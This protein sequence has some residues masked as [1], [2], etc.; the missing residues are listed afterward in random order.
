MKLSS[1]ELE[2][3]MPIC[4]PNSNNKNCIVYKKYYFI[5]LFEI[6][7]FCLYTKKILGQILY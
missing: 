5:D 1:V 6:E 7:L 3:H 2:K 4:Y